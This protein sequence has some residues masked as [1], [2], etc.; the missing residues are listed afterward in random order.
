MDPTVP[1]PGEGVPA[2][3]SVRLPGEEHV[4][5]V[6]DGVL[7]LPSKV[8]AF[9]VKAWPHRGHPPMVAKALADLP[10]VV[11]LKRQPDVL[12]CCRT[13]ALVQQDIASYWRSESCAASGAR[14]SLAVLSFALYSHSFPFPQSLAARVAIV[15]SPLLSP[16][17]DPSHPLVVDSLLAPSCTDRGPCLLLHSRI[18]F[19]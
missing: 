5:G 8:S 9:L 15:V 14:V 13:K 6:Q 1:F 12:F 3:A 17:V 4:V 7:L 16:L 10:S 18:T 19:G 11:P 2:P